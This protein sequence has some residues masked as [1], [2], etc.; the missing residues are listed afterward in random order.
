M[1]DAVQYTPF[2]TPIREFKPSH[3][4]K[5]DGLLPTF[6]L[7]LDKETGNTEI[8]QGEP[9]DLYAQIQSYKDS[10]G[11]TAA[12]ELI[13]RGLKAPD[14]FADDPADYGDI[15]TMPDNINDAY[16]ANE[17]AAAAA[18]AY[19]IEGIQ[20]QAELDSYIKSMV[21]KELAASKEASAA[22]ATDT[23]EAK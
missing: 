10:C 8:V 17:Q 5:N 16:Q 6:E 7:K 1:S 11:M 22:P 13:A 3:F 15:S 21:A 14:A 9:I 18:R 19:G 4:P 2:G 23:K 12:Q 20:T